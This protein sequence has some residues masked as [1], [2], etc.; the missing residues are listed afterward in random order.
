MTPIHKYGIVLR[1]VQEKDAEF[2]LKLRTNT[3]LNRYIS[4][5]SDNL[6]DQINW[7]RD[8]KIRELSDLEFYF[9]AEDTEG[10][11]HG[12]IRLY[13]F[14][15]KSFEIG[16]WVFLPKSPLGMAAKTHFLAI[17]TGFNYLNADFCK[18]EIRKM[19]VTVLR[20]MKEFKITLVKEDDLNYYFSLTKEN[21]FI[22]RNKLFNFLN[23]GK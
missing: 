13:N 7:I 12:T 17:E 3:Y 14:D 1:L 23:G 10:K 8:Y 2:I 5:T 21:F 4:P 19:N 9:I 6:T 22:R 18:I 16:S 20:Y 15:E 11:R